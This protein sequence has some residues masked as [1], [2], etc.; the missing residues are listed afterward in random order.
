YDGSGYTML[1]NYLN[2][3]VNTSPQVA[4]GG[5]LKYFSQTSAS[6]SA[7]QSYTVAGYNLTGNVTITPPAS[8]E[9][10]LDGTTW[11][12]NSNPLVLTPAAGTLASTTIMVRLNAAAQGTYAGNITHVSTG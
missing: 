1:E 2:N 8:Y 6:P 5:S 12:N 10:S 11:Y 4:V 7:T 9:V 3:V